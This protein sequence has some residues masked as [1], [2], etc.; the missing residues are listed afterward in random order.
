[1]LND[2]SLGARVF[3]IVNAVLLGFV[4]LLFVLPFIYIF[5]ISISDPASVAR[6]E[7]GLFPTGINFVAYQ[8]IL[9]TKD[10]FISYYNSIRYA[11]FGTIF[12]LFI[13]CITAYPLSLGRL[14]YRKP[15]T[16]FFT[17]T[18]FFSGGM[19]P[20]FLL[21][22]DLKLIDTMWVMILPAAFSFWNII[23]MR[24][25]FQSIPAELYESA[26]LDGANDWVILF[27]I[28][29]P[30]SKAIIATICL[31]V[32]VAQWNAYFPA[33]MYLNSPNMQPLTIFLRRLLVANEI[34][35]DTDVRADILDPIAFAGRASSMKMAAIFITIGPIVLV[36]PFI[37]KYFVKGIMVGS[38]KG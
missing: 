21:Y 27:R 8:R 32:A 29:I 19:I 2:K 3:S 28:V 15:I 36:Y 31:F 9:E 14:K 18:M 11:V 30:L 37:Q 25:N 20:T 13:A 38:I 16:L 17:F 10:L 26:Y 12:A 23:L 33:L 1:M 6:S 5:S 24:S 7:V 34:F 35:A 4:V 22:S